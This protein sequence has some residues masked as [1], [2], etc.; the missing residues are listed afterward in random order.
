MKSMGILTLL[1]G[2]LLVFGCSSQSTE[3]VE[4]IGSDTMVILGQAWAEKYMELN[5]NKS[6]SVTG[7]GSGVG[8][9]A[10]IEGNVDIAQASR[11]MKSSEIEKAEANGITPVQTIVAYDGI[12]IIVNPQNPIDQLTVEQVGQ[13][14]KGETTNWAD[15][16]GNSGAIGIYSRES[17]SGT[18]EFMK[19]HVLKKADYASDARYS[20]GNSAIVESISQDKTGV[21]YVGVAYA[22]QRNDVKILK[23]SK[24]FSS[25]GYVPN[26]ETVKS[27]DYAIARSLNFYTDGEPTGKTKEFI[28]FVLSEEGKAIVED[29]GYFR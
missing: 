26:K 20:S 8:I 2:V 16:G 17:S 13:I 6:V 29:I 22:K 10:M 19:E 27:G 11:E 28:D 4:I 9:A 25:P 1:V 3:Q 18:Y 24:D 7:G 15:V 23:I 5:P 21:G 12:A 14:F